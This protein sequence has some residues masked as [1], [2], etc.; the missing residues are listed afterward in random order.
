LKIKQQ[1]NVIHV[2]LENYVCFWELRIFFCLINLLLF[3]CVGL[4]DNENNYGCYDDLNSAYL[5]GCCLDSERL[6]AY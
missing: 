4:Y 6:L 2:S 1:G 3:S 5:L